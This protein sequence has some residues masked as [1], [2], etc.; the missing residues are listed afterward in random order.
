PC[1]RPGCAGAA[2]PPS[3]AW[4]ATSRRPP[5]RASA[6][7]TIRSRFVHGAHGRVPRHFVDRRRGKPMPKPTIVLV[8][9]AWA[10]ASSWDDVASALQ[11]D[12]FTV[13][14]PPNLLRSVTVDAP[15]ISS[16]INQQTSG[17]V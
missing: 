5:R 15:Y 4:S 3:R 8:H 7:L 6:A 2:S 10:D 1:T 16:F 13:L 14:A 12:G 9:G 17:P 11:R